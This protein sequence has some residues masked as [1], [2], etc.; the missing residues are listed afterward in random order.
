MCFYLFLIYCYSSNIPSTHLNTV[1]ISY[2]VRKKGKAPSSLSSCGTLEK[3][4]ENSL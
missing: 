2:V 1:V 3:E 4:I